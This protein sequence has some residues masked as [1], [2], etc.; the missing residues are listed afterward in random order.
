MVDAKSEEE[1]Q[2]LD[3]VS[4]PLLNPGPTFQSGGPKPHPPNLTDEEDAD[5]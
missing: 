2:A 3:V 1:A 5:V 4:S